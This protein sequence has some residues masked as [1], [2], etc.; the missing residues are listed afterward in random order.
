MEREYKADLSALREE[1]LAY[2]SEHIEDQ[3]FSVGEPMEEDKKGKSKLFL[4]LVLGILSWVRSGICFPS[5]MGKKMVTEAV[6]GLVAAGL[7]ISLRP[8]SVLTWALAIWM[9]FLVQ[10]LYF[11]FFE[12][13]LHEDQ[14]VKRD[15]FE[16]ARERAANILSSVPQR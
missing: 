4:V 13:N 3:A 15:P 11:V 6:L 9:L 8:A 7:V 10:A 2:Y 12:T 1:A 16:T 5:P 14:P